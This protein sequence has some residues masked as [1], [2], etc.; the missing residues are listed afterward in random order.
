MFSA[1]YS[2]YFKMKVGGAEYVRKKSLGAINAVTGFAQVLEPYEKPKLK[3]KRM[4]NYKSYSKDT[5]FLLYIN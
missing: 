2:S 5:S 4:R 3:F 1:F